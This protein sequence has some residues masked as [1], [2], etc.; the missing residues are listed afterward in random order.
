MF[1]DF[2]AFLRKLG[3]MLMAYFSKEVASAKTSGAAAMNCSA[4]SIKVLTLYWR[5]LERFLTNK[6]VNFSVFTL[7][8]D[9]AFQEYLQINLELK[10]LLY[11]EVF[12]YPKLAG[13]FIA[14][15]L[16]V[17][18]SLL[19]AVFSMPVES[20]SYALKMFIVSRRFMEK[21]TLESIKLS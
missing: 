13:V 15:I 2:S 11:E 10:F 1:K 20:V 12:V 8:G 16:S 9:N 4:A 17:S 21:L 3:I 14:N 19:E 18:D 7:F 6:L 5:I